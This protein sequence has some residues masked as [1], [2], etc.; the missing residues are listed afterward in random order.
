[1]PG[2]GPKCVQFLSELTFNSHAGFVL[3]SAVCG[4]LVLCLQALSEAARSITSCGWSGSICLQAPKTP[5]Q[6]LHHASDKSL[7][8]LQ[9]QQ[10][11]KCNL[12]AQTRILPATTMKTADR[13]PSESCP[14]TSGA[15][16]T[17]SPNALAR[18]QGGLKVSQA[19]SSPAV[20]RACLTRATPTLSLRD[21]LLSPCDPELRTQLVVLRRWKRLCTMPVLSSTMT[22]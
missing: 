17:F 10:P 11:W 20:R 22:K 14:A 5:P 1:M 19:P 21:L 7:R 9:A 15:P 3:P 12:L 4:F 2:S 6:T 8:Q 13:R 18:M 16:Q